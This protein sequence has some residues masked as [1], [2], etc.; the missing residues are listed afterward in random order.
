MQCSQAI[1]KLSAKQSGTLQD[2]GIAEAFGKQP[3]ITFTQEQVES[4]VSSQLAGVDVAAVRN[5]I[6][7]AT[8]AVFW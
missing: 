2:V 1:P 8:D 4:A 6:S 3:R 5:G 7:K